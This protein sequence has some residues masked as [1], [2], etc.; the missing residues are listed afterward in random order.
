MFTEPTS[1]AAGPVQVTVLWGSSAPMDITEIEALVDLLPEEGIF[2]RKA[3]NGRDKAP[4]A[5]G[6][7]KAPIEST[8][9]WPMSGSRGRAR[10]RCAGRSCRLA[11][12][13]SARASRCRRR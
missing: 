8:S 3:A 12:R 11:P 5:D 6:E 4:P 1:T 9:V 2:P 10:A 7:Y 13:C